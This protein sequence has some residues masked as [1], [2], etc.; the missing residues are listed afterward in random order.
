MVSRSEMAHP[1]TGVTGNMIRWVTLSPCERRHSCH[2]FEMD[3]GMSAGKW[4]ITRSLLRFAEV[5]AGAKSDL[6]HTVSHLEAA[7]S[8]S[9]VHNVRRMP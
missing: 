9:C 1:L 3:A 5:A 6:G 4:E 8:Y 2:S 7:M